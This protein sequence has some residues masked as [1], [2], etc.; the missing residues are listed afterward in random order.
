MSN[1]IDTDAEMFHTAFPVRG[2]S[3]DIARGATPTRAFWEEIIQ[4]LAAGGYN[5][6]AIYFEDLFPWKGIKHLAWGR[7]AMTRSEINH[8]IRYARRFGIQVMPTLA[9]CAH[10][11]QFFALPSL[12]HLDEGPGL[13]VLDADRK[14]ATEFGLTLLN[15]VLDVFPGDYVGIGGDEA[16]SLGRGRSLDRHQ[17]FKGPEIYLTYYRTL[18][19]RI[20][21]R[22]K[23][24]VIWGDMI[25]GCFLEKQLAA[26]W[27]PLLKD[28]LWKQCI[29]GNW[30][31]DS[32]AATL[33][34]KT[35][36]IRKQGFR[37]WIVPGIHDWGTLHPRVERAQDSVSTFIKTAGNV[38]GYMVTSWGDDG[39]ACLYRNMLP[40]TYLP[41]ALASG[42][43][44]Q[45][46]W[47]RV[48]GERPSITAFREL[49]GKTSVATT[50]SCL[51]FSSPYVQ[52][53]NASFAR[54]KS[55]YHKLATW[56]GKLP[57]ELQFMK[58]VCALI[59]RKFTRGVKPEAYLPL[60]RSYA[61]LWHVER[62]PFGLET[63][64]PRFWHTAGLTDCEVPKL[65]RTCHPAGGFGQIITPNSG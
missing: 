51:L 19:A 60:A 23:T 36:T 56:R 4:H 52:K 62:K 43:T 41:R 21:E 22:G 17:V 11:N 65:S 8:V 24:P 44:W 29:V 37:Q 34:E 46:E 13:G 42:R 10:M 63:I 25:L 40:L 35:R 54:A 28:P 32:P 61:G 12:K 48:S 6:L 14:E 45:E 1:R 5:L 59:H 18:I 58:Q 27:R 64:V 47:R 38:D 50:C 15:Q 55:D 30:D 49:L 26:R 2:F 33:V 53:Y 57:P 31:Y 20:L 16:W 3:L 7:S 39:R 9:L